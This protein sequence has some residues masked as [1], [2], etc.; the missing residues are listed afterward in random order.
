VSS[1][2]VSFRFVSCPTYDT[3]FC[4]QRCLWIHLPCVSGVMTSSFLILVLNFSFFLSYL[5]VYPAGSSL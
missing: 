1:P 3:C 2:I 4:T 5:N